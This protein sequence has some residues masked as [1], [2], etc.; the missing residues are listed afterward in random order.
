V[1]VQPSLPP[2]KPRNI[3]R[4][5]WEKIRAAVVDKDLYWFIAIGQWTVTMSMAVA[6]TQIC[7]DVR[8]WDILQREMEVLDVMTANRDK[9]IWAVALV[10]ISSWTTQHTALIPVKSN[11]AG[12]GS[13]RKNILPRPREAIRH[14]TLGSGHEGEPVRIRKQFPELAKPCRWPGTPRADCGL[15]SGLLSALETKDDM[16]DKLIVLEDTNGDGK[17]DKCTVFADHLNCPTGFEFYNGVC[18]WPSAGYYVSERHQRKRH[19]GLQRTRAGCIASADTH[20][21]ANSF[22]LDPGGAL[23]FQEGVFIP[24]RLKPLRPTSPQ[25]QRGGLPL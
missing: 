23:Y 24:R 5:T 2:A 16:N 4:Q 18:W 22:V 10:K 12:P 21:T 25:P 8:N 1:I 20:H 14:M 13:A 9:R 3:K 6:P 17:A 15:P 7:D 19:G 11:K